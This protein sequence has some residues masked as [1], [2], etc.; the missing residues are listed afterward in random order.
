MPPTAISTNTPES[1]ETPAPTN[2]PRPPTPTPGPAVF[3]DDFTEDIGAWLFCDVCEWRD[4]ALFM[5]PF[6]AN[7]FHD[8]ICEACGQSTY[9]RMAVDATYGEGQVDPGYGFQYDIESEG[10]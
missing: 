8:V 6:A 4:G 2:T 9:F 5:G 7:E 1:S 10:F 3:F